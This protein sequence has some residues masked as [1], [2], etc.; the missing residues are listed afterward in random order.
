M[1]QDVSRDAETLGVPDE[2]TVYCPFPDK[3]V[4]VLFMKDKKK[5]IICHQIASL[6]SKGYEIFVFSRSDK[7]C[8]M[9]CMTT[10]VQLYYHYPII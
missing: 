7:K 5:T 1:T 2:P 6:L 3:A 8:F 9:Q 4:I 10:I